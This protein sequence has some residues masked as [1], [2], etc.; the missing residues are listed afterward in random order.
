M[1]FPCIISEEWNVDNYCD[2]TW[3]EAEITIHRKHSAEVVGRFVMTIYEYE[4]NESFPQLKT[5]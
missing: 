5:Q 4:D 1:D 2:E 3:N